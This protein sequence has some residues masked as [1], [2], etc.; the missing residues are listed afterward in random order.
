MAVLP[1]SKPTTFYD[2]VAQVA[3]H[4]AGFTPGE[5][6]CEQGFAERTFTQLE[7]FG[8]Y[9]FPEVTPNHLPDSLW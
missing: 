2:L 6:G 5:D 8:S 4:C 1:R 9:G 7:G 3:I